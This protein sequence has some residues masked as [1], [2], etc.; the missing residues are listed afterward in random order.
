MHVVRIAALF[1]FGSLS[2]GANC[3]QIRV[4]D[5]QGLPVSGAVASIGQAT[6][7]A[8][9]SGVAEL[10]EQGVLRGPIRVQATGF[11]TALEDLA[12]GAS[13]QVIE[14]RI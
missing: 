2:L 9:A 7:A 13:P 5:P 6:A 11:A 14:L 1:A 4:V 12:T 10:C 3:L 8:N